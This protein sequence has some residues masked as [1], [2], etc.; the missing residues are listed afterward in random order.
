MFHDMLN[1]WQ[2][3]LS[4]ENELHLVHLYPCLVQRF[5]FLLTKTRT[6]RKYIAGLEDPN[7]LFTDCSEFKKLFSQEHNASYL[8]EEVRGKLVM[9]LPNDLSLNISEI[10]TNCYR[11]CGCLLYTSPSPRDQRGSRMPSSA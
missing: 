2:I 7:S 1:L 11:I 3:Q 8:E 5:I 9:T 10:L 6:I 4:Q